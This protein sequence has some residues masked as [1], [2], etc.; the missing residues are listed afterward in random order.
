MRR[1]SQEAHSVRKCASVIF[2]KGELYCFAVIFGLRPS[3]IAFGSFKANIIQLKPIGFNITEYF[4]FELGVISK[5]VTHYDTFNLK[6]SIF[7]QKENREKHLYEVSPNAD[8]FLF[9]LLTLYN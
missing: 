3:Y 4:I 5:Y 6:V 1:T 9:I 2:A 7:M 8:L